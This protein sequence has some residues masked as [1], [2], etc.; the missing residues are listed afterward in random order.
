MRVR[1]SVAALVNSVYINLQTNTCM[2]AG[3]RRIN[4]GILFTNRK[5]SSF[6]SELVPK[7][8]P[9]AIAFSFSATH[10]ENT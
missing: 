3:A 8:K 4:M 2:A 9:R 1:L 5:L 7:S 10:M 6:H